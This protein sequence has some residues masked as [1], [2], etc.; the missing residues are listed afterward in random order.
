MFTTFKDGISDL[1]KKFSTGR[2]NKKEWF[3]KIHLLRGNN[4]KY[5]K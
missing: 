5:N 4:K 3:K 2:A 1:L